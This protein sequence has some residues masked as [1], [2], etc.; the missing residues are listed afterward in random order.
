MHLLDL[1]RH[2]ILTPATIQDA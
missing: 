1:A 2:A